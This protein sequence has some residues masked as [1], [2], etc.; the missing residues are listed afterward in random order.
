MNKNMEFMKTAAITALGKSGIGT[1]GEE[2]AIGNGI[3]CRLT[4]GAVLNIYVNGNYFVQGKNAETTT[5]LLKAAFDADAPSK[6][7]FWESVIDNLPRES[8][9]D[10]LPT[11]PQKAPQDDSYQ[12]GF[13]DGMNALKEMI[14]KNNGFD[15]PEFTVYLKDAVDMAAKQ[16]AEELECEEEV[17][18]MTEEEIPF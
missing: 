5:A 12:R 9:M 15:N 3:Q 7:D 10:N 4:N 13:R 11:K 2:K 16:L 6:P 17:Q 14:L 18:G 8:V 1:V